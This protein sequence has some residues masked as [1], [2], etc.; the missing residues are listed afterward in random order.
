[1]LCQLSSEI[2]WEEAIGSLDGKS[3][4]TLYEL[5]YFATFQILHVLR[6][7]NVSLIGHPLILHTLAVQGVQV[8]EHIGLSPMWPGF[9]SQL[10]I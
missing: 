7:Q 6:H 5:N 3:H 4:S 2:H 10:G 1:M 8:T 9:D